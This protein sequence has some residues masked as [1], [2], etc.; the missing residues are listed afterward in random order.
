MPGYRTAR[1]RLPLRVAKFSDFFE[2]YVT[3]TRPL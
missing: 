2:S 1:Q 3:E